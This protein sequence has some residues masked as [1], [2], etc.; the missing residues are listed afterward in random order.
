MADAH[1]EFDREGAL[2]I[3]CVN[4]LS[5]TVPVSLGQARVLEAAINEEVDCTLAI[6]ADEEDG[7]MAPTVII[8][9]SKSMIGISFG[10]DDSVYWWDMNDVQ[11]LRALSQ[12]EKG[13]TKS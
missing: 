7:P 9:I 10:G 4:G 3:L 5:V 6:D 8:H 1:I 12:H 2:S 13:K 11:A